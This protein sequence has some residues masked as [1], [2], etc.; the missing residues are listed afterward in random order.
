MSVIKKSSMSMSINQFNIDNLYFSEP[1]INN[2]IDNGTF[3]IL[4]YSDECIN[5]NSIILRIP[6]ENCH[7][8]KF[9]NKYK[10]VFNENYRKII[11]SLK[12]IE[13]MCLSK[14]HSRKEPKLNLFEQIRNNCIK[15]F[16]KHDYP[17]KPNK[18]YINFKISGVW[19]NENNFGITYKCY[20]DYN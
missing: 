7:L 2:I 13:I 10:C 15:F 17:D 1:V 8:I 5:L 19:E 18:F 20:D 3:Y 11:D 16:S 12:R 4:Q 14:I 6:I 9:Q